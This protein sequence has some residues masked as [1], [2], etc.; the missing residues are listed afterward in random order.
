MEFIEPEGWEPARGYTNGIVAE[1]KLVFVA[2]QIGW[3]AQ[4]QFQSDDFIDQVRQT[5]Q[6][7]QLLKNNFQRLNPASWGQFTGA[8]NLLADSVKRHVSFCL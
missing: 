8:L 4:Q 7:L 5:K 2:G 3:D 6:T 1:G